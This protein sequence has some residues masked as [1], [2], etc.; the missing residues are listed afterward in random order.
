MKVKFNL[1]FI[2]ILIFFIFHLNILKAQQLN[3]PKLLKII[4]KDSLGKPLNLSTISINF[5]PIGVTDIKG[6]FV[7]ENTGGILAISKPDYITKV[8]QL[9][10]YWQGEIK[11]NL[12]KS[13]FKEP[14]NN[15]KDEEIE[16]IRKILIKKTPLMNQKV[17]IFNNKNNYSLFYTDD[18]GDLKIKVDKDSKNYLL[19]IIQE[20]NSVFIYFSYLDEKENNSVLILDYGISSKYTFNLFNDILPDTIIFQGKDSYFNLPFYQKLKIK[21][22]YTVYINSNDY[23]FK[24]NFDIYFQFNLNFK[25]FSKIYDDLFDLKSFAQYEKAILSI[26]LKI[27]QERKIETDDFIDLIES[28]LGEN[29]DKFIFQNIFNSMNFYFD[30]NEFLILKIENKD[31]LSISNLRIYDKK[32]FLIFDCLLS[33]SL[34]L[35]AIYFNDKYTINWEYYFD[36]FYDNLINNTNILGKDSYFSIIFN[37]K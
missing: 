21:S 14:D 12:N 19:Y 24:E 23:N 13:V 32:G 4:V 22:P 6:E 10:A 11:V 15:N 34:I 7:F 8:M 35:P 20:L 27:D 3:P 36:S 28:R 1:L 29:K 5:K 25:Y 33:D 26:K 31:F 30:K 16:Y 9:P 17:L 37:I 2:I 18:N